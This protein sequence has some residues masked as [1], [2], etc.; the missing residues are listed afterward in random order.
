M[1]RYLL[2]LVA[3]RLV[4]GEDGCSVV[5]AHEALDVMGTDAFQE[6]E[7]VE[8]GLAK[9]QYEFPAADGWDHDCLA[10]DADDLVDLNN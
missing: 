6:R 10:T 1:K 8:I 5:F 7:A 3:H 4:T 9:L 2:S